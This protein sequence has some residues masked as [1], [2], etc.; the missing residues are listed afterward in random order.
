MTVTFPRNYEVDLDNIPDDFEDQ[1]VRC[2]CDYTRGTASDYTYQDKLLFIDTMVEHLHKVD[3]PYDRVK[4]LCLDKF[5]WDLDTYGE[6]PDKEDYQSVGFMEMC[7]EQ[8]RSDAHLY[9]HF[10]VEDHHVYEKIMK[11]E[12]RAIKVVMEWDHDKSN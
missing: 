6:L 1:I 12:C 3:D 7:Y 10:G 8:G 2:F 11:L 9:S 4:Q 5:E